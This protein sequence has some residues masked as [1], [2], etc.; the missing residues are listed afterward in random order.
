MTGN[1]R[2]IRLTPLAAA[3]ALLPALADTPLAR[4]SA[5]ALPGVSIT[6]TRLPKDADFVAP[7]VAVLSPDGDDAGRVHDI[8]SLFVDEPGVSVGRDPARR[9]NAG[10]SIRGIEGNRVQMTIDGINLPQVYMGGG[11]ALS[12]RDMVELDN[13]SAVEVIKGPYS[14]LYGADAL[15]GVVAYR[16]LDIDDLLAK[17]A[18]QG[19]RVRLG[20]TGVDKSKKAGAAAGMR[21]GAVSVL[22]SYTRR[23]GENNKSM[24]EDKSATS[25]RTAA[26]PLDWHSDAI[27][28]KLGWELAKG[29]KLGFAQDSF[30]RKGDGDYL[31]SR[32][33]PLLAQTSTDNVKRDRSS[34]SYDFSDTGNGLIGVHLGVY[35]QTGKSLED[36]LEQRAGNVLRTN[37]SSFEQTAWGLDGQIT[38]RYDQGNMIHTLVWGGDFNRTETSRPRMRTQINAN[39]SVSTTV[40]GE[41]FPQKT[42]PD[43]DNDRLGLFVQDEIAFASGLSITPSLRYDRYSLKPK[44]DALYAN[45]NPNPDNVRKS[46]DSAVSPRMMFSLPFNEHWTGFAQF[47][48]G[49]RTPNFD[50][51]VL[52]FVNSAF[53]YEVRPN[54]G[55]KAETSRSAEFGARYRAT[56]TEFAIT[57][58]QNRYKNFIASTLVSS[59]DTNGNGVANEYQAQNIGRV[60]VQG[61]EIKSAWRMHPNLKLRGTLAYAKADD[62][63]RNQA[64]DGV[65]PLNGLVALDFD[66]EQ[67]G[68]SL[69]LRAAKSKSRTSASTLFKAPGYGVFDLSGRMQLSRQAS[70]QA[71]I[72]NLADKKYWLWS[73]VK[74]QVAS[75]NV[76][77]RYTQSGRTVAA[78]FEYRF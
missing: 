26:N 8:Q 52:V 51:G 50:D 39:G 33:G 56:N 68:S 74:G 9:G 18:T 16:S 15:G 64:Y 20:Y 76:L 44:A 27:L 35:R 65:D 19:G 4:T 28:A 66:T 53:G 49:F 47:G 43:N 11:A 10:V 24:G 54:P 42:F 30:R 23:Q 21:S 45:A 75:S 2:F 29:H 77:D 61:L 22:F 67:W 37:N 71:G 7:N 78:N 17:D 32:T 31:S 25:T 48:T 55:L 14:G 58:Y 62:L 60:R 40:A 73:D 38:Q 41:V 36:T 12:G 34:V 70:L 63:T 6:A 57:A 5:E 13:L 72:Y 3:L 59:V 46:S 1:T 69:T